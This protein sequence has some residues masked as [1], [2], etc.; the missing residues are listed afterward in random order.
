MVWKI[1]VDVREPERCFEIMQSLG[2]PVEKRIEKADY[3][4]D[5]AIVERKELHDF[6]QSAKSGRLIQQLVFL[7]RDERLPL[8]ALHG[9]F[10]ELRPF[11][12]Q[13]AI[14]MLAS[15]KVRYG[16][17]WFLT[18]DLYTCLQAIGKILIKIHEKK[19]GKPHIIRIKVK[20]PHPTVA[21][22]ARAFRIPVKAAEALHQKYPCFSALCGATYKDLQQLNGIGET[23]AKRILFYLQ[24]EKS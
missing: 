10:A 1:Y 20:H 21:A 15:I 11:D 22:Y 19:V 24:G 4:T 5:E 13:I 16:I 7:S 3:V 23:R 8:L 9:D 17:D 12:Y 2:F 6:V 14:G 18:P